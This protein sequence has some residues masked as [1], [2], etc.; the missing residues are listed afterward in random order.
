[1]PHADMVRKERLPLNTFL[2]IGDQKVSSNVDTDLKP[3]IRPVA[4]SGNCLQI[5]SETDIYDLGGSY[6]ASV[7]EALDF[8][9][10]SGNAISLPRKTD[11]SSVMFNIIEGLYAIE[12]EAS[13]GYLEGNVWDMIYGAACRFASLTWLAD[14]I[15]DI[16]VQFGLTADKSVLVVSKFMPS[17]SGHLYDNFMVKRGNANVN[18]DVGQANFYQKESERLTMEQ[19]RMAYREEKIV[20]NSLEREMLKIEKQMRIE[21]VLHNDT[22]SV[23]ALERKEGS[24]GEYV[25]T[26]IMNMMPRLLRK[27]EIADVKED[28]IDYYSWHFKVMHQGL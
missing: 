14:T 24:I 21:D 19:A 4:E 26:D 27:I 22:V 20:G 16:R 11:V 9:F 17:I 5:A 28:I 18:V 10:K 3:L 7:K 6:I 13:D 1:M 8:G 25:Y 23:A 15:K 2:I 12:R